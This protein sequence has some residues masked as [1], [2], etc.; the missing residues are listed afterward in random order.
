MSFKN[1]N[2][3]VNDDSEYQRLMCS[4]NGCQN[5]WSVNMGSPK[6]SFHQWG[7]KLQ[8]STTKVVD[9]WYDKE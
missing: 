4:V 8:N 9:V 2:V 7:A 6:C 5:R 1:L 3:P